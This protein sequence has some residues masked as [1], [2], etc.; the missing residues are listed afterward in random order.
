MELNKL[1]KIQLTNIH[2]KLMVIV[3]KFGKDNPDLQK[4]LFEAVEIVSNEN[5]KIE[6]VKE[7]FYAL[8][9]KM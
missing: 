9:S 6:D 4:E 2:S 5:K 8:V 3:S 1:E 7:A